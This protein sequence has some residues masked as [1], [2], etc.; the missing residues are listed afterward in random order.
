MVKRAAQLSSAH[1][2]VVCWINWEHLAEARVPTLEEFFLHLS[3]SCSNS[4]L[5]KQLLL[6]VAK[7][8]LV[9]LMVA[10]QEATPAVK[11]VARLK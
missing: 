10:F 2:L 11:E 4:P 8:L 5:W 9:S 1:Q 7:R 3:G 6:P